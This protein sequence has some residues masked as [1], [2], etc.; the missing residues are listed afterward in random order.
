MT[1]R[2]SKEKP[3]MGYN[4]SNMH[5]YSLTPKEGTLNQTAKA[6]AENKENRDEE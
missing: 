2:I 1:D 6:A 4:G 5:G 3:D